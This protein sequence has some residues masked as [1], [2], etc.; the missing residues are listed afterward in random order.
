VTQIVIPEL[1]VGQTM[2]L[3]TAS[4]ERVTAQGVAALPGASSVV[5]D[6]VNTVDATATN[7]PG[8][9]FTAANSS[10]GYVQ[11]IVVARMPGTNNTVT[12]AAQTTFRRSSI[13]SYAVGQLTNIGGNAIAAVGPQ[14]AD[15]T[16]FAAASINIVNSSGTLMLQVTGIGATN[17]T[18]NALASWYKNP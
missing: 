13:G 4:G 10:G 7:L 16:A 3:A 11:L 9:G 6:T 1:S 15:T 2:Q 14:N 5:S 12:W 17:I 18:W 8:T